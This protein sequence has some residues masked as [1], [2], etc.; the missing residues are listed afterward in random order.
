MAQIDWNQ[1]EL[2]LKILGGIALLWIGYVV[3]RARRDVME[4]APDRPE[5]LLDAFEDAYHRGD[6]SREEYLRVR[7]TLGEAP[8]S[9]SQAE[10][11]GEEARMA[12]PTSAG[13]ERP[14]E[15]FDNGAA[16]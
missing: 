13:G 4:S 1:A 14:G 15:P 11:P 9:M 2:L 16:G 6:M 8:P 5:E 7:Q 10:S 3:W 12:P